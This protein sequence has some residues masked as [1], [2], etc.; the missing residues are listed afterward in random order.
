MTKPKWKILARHKWVSGAIITESAMENSYSDVHR[1]T[2]TIRKWNWKIAEEP[3]A[4]TD[5]AERTSRIIARV[6]EI[7]DRIDAGDQTIFDEEGIE[8]LK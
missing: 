8:E 1:F 5:M 6:K 4:H 7:R 2:A 3:T